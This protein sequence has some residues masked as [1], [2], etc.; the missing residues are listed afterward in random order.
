[1]TAP[2]S[3]ELLARDGAARAGRLATP[4]GTVE[5]PAFMPVATVGSVKS[6]SPADVRVSGGQI[7]LAN[8]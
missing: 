5:T 2:V 7:V 1:V 8:T 3:F 6:L 4:H